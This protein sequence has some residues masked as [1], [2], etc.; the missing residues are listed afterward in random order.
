M[1]QRPILIISLILFISFA[2]F[3][4]RAQN[5]QAGVFLG[6]S[7]SQVSGDQLGGFNKAGLYGGGFVNTPLGEKSMLQMEMSYIGKGSRPTSAQ[8]EANPYNRYPTLNYIEVPVLFIYTVKTSITVE[9]GLAFG[10]LVY[11]REEDFYGERPIERPYNSTEF[12]FLFGVGYM[13]S[14]KISLNSRLDN[15]ILPIREHESGGTEGLNQ[16]QYNTEITF[17]LRYHF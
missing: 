9:G 12:S 1:N 17:S 3:L 6:I 15:S 16:G 11:S 4:S 8:A 14:E 5:F 13:L 10:V 7:S 2:P